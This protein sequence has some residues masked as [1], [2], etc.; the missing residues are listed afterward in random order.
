LNRLGFFL[1]SQVAASGSSGGLALAWHPRVELECFASDKNSIS[2]WCFSDPSHSPW[3]LSCVYGPPNRRDRRA[4]WDSFAS[5][6]E[7]FEASWLCI[8][9]FNSVVDQTKKSGGR[10][11]DSSSYC[12]F[13]NFIDHFG[14][15]DVGFVGNSFT[16]SNNI[17]GLE[18]IKERLDRGLTSRAWVHLHPDFSLIHLPAHNLDQNPIFLTTNSTSCFLP[19]PFR[20]EEFWSKDP[21]CEHVVEAAWQIYFPNYPTACLSKKLTN[22]KSALIKWNSLH[23]GNIHKRIKETLNILENLLIK[24]ESL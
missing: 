2:T 1:I 3:I 5:I 13:R 14:M 6:G 4:F 16:W 18:N 9:D 19:R 22:T 20:F 21:T 17:Q 12:P 11:V 15:I 7:G 10:P 24:E 8:G 23:F